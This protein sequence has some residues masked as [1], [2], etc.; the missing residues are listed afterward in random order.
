MNRNR[1]MMRDMARRR[2]R[3]GRNPYGSRGGYVVSDRA[4]G[5]YGYDMRGDY[6]Y[7]DREYASRGGD[8]TYSRYAD[9]TMGRDYERGRQYDM[10]DYGDYG[11]RSDYGRGANYDYASRDY[12]HES[13]YLSDDELMKFSKRLMNEIEEKDKNFFTAENIKRRAEAMG[14][15][16]DHF[17]FEEFYTTVLMMFTD[18]SKTLGSANMDIYLRL[19]KDWLCDEDVSAQYGEKLSTYYDY[20][21]EGM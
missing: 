11:M 20:I 1:I 4:R 9:E 15:K 5:D 18:Y 2:M 13:T 7:G 3:D 10:A 21:V 14:I 6:N 16:F 17:S 19:A 12:A 8:R